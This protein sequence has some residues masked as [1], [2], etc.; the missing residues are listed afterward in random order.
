M[1]QKVTVLEYDVK[2]GQQI[3]KEVEM[4]MPDPTAIENERRVQEIK[5]R[6]AEIDTESIRPLRATVDGSASEFDTQK[7]ATLETEAQALRTEMGLLL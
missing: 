3:S 1:L 2:T 6:L 4:D 7:L 5:Q